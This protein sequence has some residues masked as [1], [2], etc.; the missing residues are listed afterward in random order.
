MA[1]QIPAKQEN[2]SRETGEK[3][4]TRRHLLQSE[5]STLHS[6]MLHCSISGDSGCSGDDEAVT[7]D[8]TVG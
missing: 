1:I 3:L 8:R 2:E 7:W 5:K 4:L 6:S